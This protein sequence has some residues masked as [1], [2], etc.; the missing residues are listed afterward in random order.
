MENIIPMAGKRRPGRP[1]ATEATEPGVRSVGRGLAVLEALAEQPEGIG[2]TD[3]TASIEMP[4]VSTHR[5][6]RT[7]VGL[8]YVREDPASG[9]YRLGARFLQLAGRALH[10]RTQLRTLARGFLQEL[11]QRSGETANLATLD[12]AEASFLDQVQ[13]DRMVR[14][15]TFLRAP[16][17]CSGTGKSLLAYQPDETLEQLLGRMAL[18]PL[19]PH[20]I[21]DLA[22][23]RA[24]L[25]R[26][27]DQGYSVDDEEMEVG[28][29]CIAAPVLVDGRAVVAVSIAG[30]TTRITADEVRPLSAIVRDVAARLSDSVASAFPGLHAGELMERFVG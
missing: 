18:R 20:T 17:H 12:G 6:L 22:R 25:E 7:L 1:R 15:G 14:A 10:Q 24:E 16:L 27:R 13:C 26:V 30:P 3:L 4:A 21:V 28:T 29:R 8:G 11:V 19:T 23:F 5:L 9:H 2:F